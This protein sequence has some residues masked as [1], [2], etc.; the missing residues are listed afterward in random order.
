MLVKVL[1]TAFVSFLVYVSLV[2]SLG[3]DELI[4]GLVIAAIVGIITRNLLVSDEKK[5]LNPRRWLSALRYL[6]V[7][8]F[9]YEP[10]AHWDVVKRVFTMNL[11]PSIVRVP[12]SLKSEYGVTAVGNSITNTPGTVVVDVDERRGYYYVHWINA[13]SVEE[14]FCYNNISKGFEGLVRRFLC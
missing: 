14:E 4:I 8:W 10:I 9:Y 7:Y 13:P 3:T 12:Y 2:G 6:A 1:F 5:V 11:R